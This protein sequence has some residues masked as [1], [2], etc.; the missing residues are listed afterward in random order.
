MD[1]RCKDFANVLPETLQ[2]QLRNNKTIEI[3]T[4]RKKPI[5]CETSFHLLQ[6]KSSMEGPDNTQSS[7]KDHCKAG[8]QCDLFSLSTSFCGN[9]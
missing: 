4:G 3:S 1:L 2:L 6:L 5:W 7:A 8:L 9:K